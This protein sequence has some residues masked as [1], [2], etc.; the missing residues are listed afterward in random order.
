MKRSWGWLF[1]ILFGLV[2]VAMVALYFWP[3]PTLADCTEVSGRVR[4]VYVDEVGTGR[5][6]RTQERLN[7]TLEGSEQSFTYGATDPQYD[8]V[9]ARV[10]VLAE[11]RIWHKEPPSFIFPLYSK[12][13]WRIDVGGE[14][15]VSYSTLAA[16]A[17]RAKGIIALVGLGIFGLL[18]LIA[19]R[20]AFQPSRKG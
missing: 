15:V 16:D 14:T 11:A 8:E 6:G 4:A 19:L 18:T 5:A 20:S 13:L 12:E 1:S 9:K 10:R 2:C 3:V 17:G 7:F